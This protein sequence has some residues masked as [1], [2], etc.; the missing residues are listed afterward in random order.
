MLQPYMICTFT[1][2]SCRLAVSVIALVVSTSPVI[3]E[4]IVR[5]HFIK[6]GTDHRSLTNLYDVTRCQIFC[7]HRGG[8]K[9]KW[10]KT[11]K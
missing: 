7:S 1:F 4:T 10:K 6:F 8:F 2:A 11:I 5:T 9:N 3:N